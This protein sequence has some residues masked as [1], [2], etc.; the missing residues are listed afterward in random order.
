MTYLLIPVRVLGDSVPTLSLA[1]RATVLVPLFP[2]PFHIL[3]NLIVC[4][5]LHLLSRVSGHW[6]IFG[7]SS[8]WKLGRGETHDIGGPLRP[9]TLSQTG[10]HFSDETKRSSSGWHG[11]LP[12]G[13]CCNYTIVGSKATNRHEY[14]F[15][16]KILRMF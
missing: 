12:A 14:I 11:L 15:I 5:K 13:R 8:R 7:I 4:F 9:V 2:R 3:N 1:R 6:G 10:S 16:N